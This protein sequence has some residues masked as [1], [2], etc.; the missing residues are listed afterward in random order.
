[1]Y[2]YRLLNDTSIIFHLGKDAIN[3]NLQIIHSDTLF[4][5]IIN[6]FT[7][8]YGK[9]FV[10]DFIKEFGNRNIIISS[11]FY[12]I[13]IVDN[14]RKYSIYFFP[15]PN[16]A[17]VDLKTI[18]SSNNIHYVSMK[19]LNE[20]ISNY[21]SDTLSSKLNSDTQ[22]IS[23]I[24]CCEKH[25]FPYDTKAAIT[26]K[27]TEY[28]A[29][30]SRMSSQINLNK[31]YANSSF[32]L[33]RTDNDK[34]LIQPGMFFLVDINSSFLDK[35]DA[36]IRLMCDEGLGGKRSTG[37][38]QF[39]KF[40]RID[41]NY[42]SD[43]FNKTGVKINLSLISPSVNDLKDLS[44][45]VIRYSSIL[46]GGW[47]PDN[48]KTKNVRMIKEGSIFKAKLHGRLLNITPYKF[49]EHRIFRNG[50]GFFL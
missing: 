26:H 37:R 32:V 44:N 46:R 41:F 29:E 38:G 2:L 12:F 48:I 5:A 14:N 3:D 11:V 36:S 27:L 16:F 40:E 18:P 31:R 15:I 49:T 47:A 28:K 39:S 17:K 1:M 45:N 20:L 43:F 8:I 6:C 24:F 10:D 4:S 25:E 34:F 33:N 42:D 30:F 21:N 35:F 9:H 50:V 13:D 23:E 7:L 19:L 22:V